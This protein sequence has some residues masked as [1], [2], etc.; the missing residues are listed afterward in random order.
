MDNILREI[1]LE[2]RQINEYITYKKNEELGKIEMYHK[3]PDPSF[4]FKFLKDTELHSSRLPK[5]VN[6]SHSRTRTRK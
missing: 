5:A 4:G 6:Q 3:L 1:L 2:L